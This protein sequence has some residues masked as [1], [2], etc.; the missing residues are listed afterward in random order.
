MIAGLIL[1]AGEGTRFGP[2]PKLLAELDGRPLVEYAIRAQCG[3]AELERVAVVLGAHADELRSRVDFGRAEVVVCENWSDGQ[4]ASLRRGLS[5]LHDAAKVI[6]TL[7]DEPLITSELV[8]RFV[9]EA[10]GARAVY[11]GR[12]GHPVV[13]GP[14]QIRRVMALDGDRGARDV[15]GDGPK[16]ELGEAKAGQDVDTKEDLERMRDEARAIV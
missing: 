9:A 15:L 3:V 14:D 13:L 7:G 1:A 5:E 12:P 10:P 4:S 8:A 16:I 11:N 2:E 6:V